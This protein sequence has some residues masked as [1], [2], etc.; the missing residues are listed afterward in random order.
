M[1]V[2]PLDLPTN[3][4]DIYVIVS[5]ISN[6]FFVGKTKAGNAYNA[7]KDHARFKN[8]QTKKL[9]MQSEK[10]KKFPQMYILESLEITEQMAFRHCIAWTKY[11]MDQGLTPL[12]TAMIVGYTDDMLED[13]K[14]FYESIAPLRL[15]EVLSEEKLRV[16]NYQKKD[17]SAPKRSKE[18]IKLY[19]STKQYEKIE[20]R[21]KSQ[22]LTLSAFCKNAALESQFITIE[23]PDYSEYIAEVRGAKVILRQILYAIHTNG[24][25]YP[26]DMENIQKAVDK[27]CEQEE[28]FREAFRENTKVLMKLLPKK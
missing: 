25:Y 12:S 17:K 8:K 21:A 20:E 22:N 28:A 24:K 23:A 1:R 14:D 7:Y 10:E 19:V 11:F 27:I 18:E 2:L 4:D 15:N 6:E 26:A 3:E 5:Q 16:K 13:T 9:F